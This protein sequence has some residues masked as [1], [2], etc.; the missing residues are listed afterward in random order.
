VKDRPS[1]G[2]PGLGHKFRQ[3]QHLWH[4]R[5]RLCRLR[6]GTGA[7]GLFN[8]SGPADRC[9]LKVEREIGIVRHERPLEALNVAVDRRVRSA[10]AARRV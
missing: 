10:L 5:P 3:P 6:W 7:S 8:L 2:A 9:K 1:P 4:S